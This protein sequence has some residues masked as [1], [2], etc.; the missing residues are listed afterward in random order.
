M[1]STY[2][3]RFA[4][5]VGDNSYLVLTMRREFVFR[6]SLLRRLVFVGLAEPLEASNRLLAD[7]LRLDFFLVVLSYLLLLLLLVLRRM[8]GLLIWLLRILMRWVLLMPIL[9]MRLLVLGVVFR[10]DIVGTAF[11]DKVRRRDARD[12][13]LFAFGC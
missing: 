10:H 1:V 9:G 6:F 4:L 12:L 7:V 3:M 11:V 5:D 13:Y 8:V 2:Y